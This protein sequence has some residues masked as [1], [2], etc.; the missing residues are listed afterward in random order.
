MNSFRFQHS[1]YS[2]AA[3]LCCENVCVFY[4]SNSLYNGTDISTIK[5]KYNQFSV[6]LMPMLMFILTSLCTSNTYITSSKTILAPHTQ[7]PALCF[8][9]SLDFFWAS[10]NLPFLLSRISTQLNIHRAQ[11]KKT[12]AQEIYL[13]V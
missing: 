9:S 3:A 4:L 1:F 8:F 2:F 5:L 13:Y 6:L 11:R 7:L 12:S 10:N